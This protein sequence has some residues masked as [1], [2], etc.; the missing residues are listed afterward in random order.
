MASPDLRHIN[1]WIF[2][3]D[4]TLYQADTNLFAEVEQ[5]MTAFIARKLDIHP[6]EAYTLQHM[7]YRSYG[8]TLTGLVKFHGIDP[9]EFL[10]Y[11]HDINLAPLHPD[12]RLRDA[13]EWLPGRRTIFTNGCRKHALRVLEKIG[14]SGLWDEIWDLRTVDW[15]PKPQLSA[16]RRIVEVG[17]FEPKKAVMFEDVARNLVPAFDLGMTTVW[18]KNDSRWSLQAPGTT[19][20][21]PDHIHYTIDD[22]ALFLQTVSV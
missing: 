12:P 17:R 6:G 11:V 13:L 4:N 21:P 14:L 16:Y 3:L 22:L 5:R 8:S 19:E 1:T 20:A 18:L 10:D 15:V 7:Y 9:G 2:D